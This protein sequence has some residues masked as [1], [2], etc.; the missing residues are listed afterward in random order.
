MHIKTKKFIKIII[1]ILSVGIFIAIIGYYFDIYKP[2]QDMITKFIT[3]GLGGDL[4]LKEAC[5]SEF[6][7]KEITNLRQII[8]VDQLCDCVVAKTYKTLKDKQIFDQIQTYNGRW[9]GDFR[10]FMRDTLIQLNYTLCDAEFMNG[11][12]KEYKQIKLPEIQISIY[13]KRAALIN[14]GIKLFK[15]FINPH[16]AETADIPMCVISMFY[17]LDNEQVEVMFSANADRKKKILIEMGEYFDDQIQKYGSEYVRYS[18]D[19]FEE[20]I[21]FAKSM[22]DKCFK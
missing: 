19:I 8:Y 9:N 5:V 10:D 17:Q 18:I 15:D 22:N 12:K 13:C 20:A 21:G 4:E 11:N 3:D 1:P 2:K 7:P 14:M 16:V 6:S